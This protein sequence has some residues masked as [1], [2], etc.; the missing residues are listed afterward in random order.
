MGSKIWIVPVM[1]AV[2]LLTASLAISAVPSAQNKQK[3]GVLLPLTEA[4]MRP[5]GVGC[6]CTFT[7]S[8][9]NN[10]GDLLMLARNSL[11]SRTGAGRA[12]CPISNI[13]IAL[14]GKT[15]GTARCGTRSITVRT[16]TTDP[17]DDSG[18]PATVTIRDGKQTRAI[19]GTWSC[20]C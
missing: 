5:G 18:A 4:D 6:S 12:I 16:G 19:H 1:A 20:A 9:G 3:A 13:Q 8:E 14:I 11:Y 17:E 2:P 7:V 10:G 15:G